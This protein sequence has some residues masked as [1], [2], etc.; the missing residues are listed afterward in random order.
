[1]FKPKT[2]GGFTEQQ[3]LALIESNKRVEPT[4]AKVI[5]ALLEEIRSL[6]DQLDAAYEDLAG[7]DW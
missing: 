4:V 6:E 5:S 2:Y 3:L 7:A 1:M